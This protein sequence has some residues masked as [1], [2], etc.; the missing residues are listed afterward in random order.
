LKRKT[1]LAGLFGLVGIGKA[2]QWKE[3]HGP[4]LGNAGSTRA[5]MVEVRP[6]MACP[7]DMPRAKVLNNQCPVCSEIAEAYE[8][9]TYDSMLT[10]CRGTA[11]PYV[12]QCDPKKAIP[13]GATERLTRCKRC[14]A[15]FWQD[16][17]N[18]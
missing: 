7:A 9:P 1:F 11:D 6:D 2:Q 12:V 13:Y 10:N 18:Q 15:A 5:R 16:A 14:N 8:R 17:V 3:C 4:W